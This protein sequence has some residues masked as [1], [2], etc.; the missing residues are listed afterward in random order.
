MPR[1]K[2]RKFQID[3]YFLGKQARSPAWCRCYYDPATG[4]TR[5]FSLG[6]VDFEEAKQKLTTWYILECQ[7]KDQ[8]SSDVLLSTLFARY[9]E[10]YGKTLVSAVTVRAYLNHW[11]D[12]YSDATLQEAADLSRQEAF[13]NWLVEEKGLSLNTVRKII[14]I[15]KSAMNWA[16]KRG[17][18]AQVPYFENVKPPASPPKG[19][20]L[21]IEEIALLLRHTEQPHLK[22]F[23]LLMI[24]TLARPQA[25][26]ELEFSQIDFKRRII[27]LNP[28]GRTQTQK[29]RPTVKLPEFLVPILEAEQ[30]K[31]IHERVIT[32]NGQPIKDVKTSWRSLRAKAGFGPEVLPYSIRRTMSMYLREQSVPA[33]EVA[34]QLGHASGFR[35]TEIYTS[36]S[37]DYLQYAVK[38][39]DSYFD[40]V[41]GNAERS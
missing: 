6:T 30:A 33:W 39:I 8:P 22:L 4:Q 20:A 17:E 35:T 23:I 7:K 11:L 5:R 25:V 12:F 36:H 34:A 1:Y 32:F 15:G 9:Y 19:R 40:R 29:V 14:T 21:E 27:D 31:Y 2:R 10:K 24:G 37:P 28:S 3:K 13:R 16:Y 26:I 41:F 18:L 38:A